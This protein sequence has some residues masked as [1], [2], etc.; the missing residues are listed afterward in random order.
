MID[1]IYN[2][3]INNIDITHNEAYLLEK[4]PLDKLINYADK[5][6]DKYCSNVFDICSIIN[7][8]SGKCSQDCKFCAQS[9]HY[10][11]EL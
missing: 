3:I 9:S 4:A 2:K 8:K 5:I 1:K 10:N 6:R 7:A 11:T